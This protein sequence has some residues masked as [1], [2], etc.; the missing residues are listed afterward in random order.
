MNEC[1]SKHCHVSHNI[2]FIYLRLSDD[3][4][5]FDHCQK[6]MNII[7]HKTRTTKIAKEFLL[8]QFRTVR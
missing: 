7:Q 8:R 6:S 3:Q 2:E 1:K 4:Q 5:A